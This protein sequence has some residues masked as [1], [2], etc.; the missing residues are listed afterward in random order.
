MIIATTAT[1]T[2]KVERRGRKEV[3]VRAAAAR[4]TYHDR[5]PC[6]SPSSVNRRVLITSPP[7][8]R[9]EGIPPVH[10]HLLPGFFLLFFFFSLSLS[11]L[12]FSSI[13]S[14]NQHQACD[15]LSSRARLAPF[16]PQ[17]RRA[18]TSNVRT[19]TMMMMMMR[20]PGEETR[21]A[22]TRA[23]THTKLNKTKKKPK[24]LQRPGESESASYVH[25]RET[26]TQSKARC[27]A[28]MS[29]SGSG[30]KW[31]PD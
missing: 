6:A 20:Q 12:I 8:K 21:D 10:R 2:S 19:G 31:P 30:A 14:F 1:I 11:L 24:I 18:P 5:F 7:E 25:Q 27:H 4:R 29:G 13:A 22:H 28:M 16:F 26:Q 9:I 17:N 3:S 15:H 23:R